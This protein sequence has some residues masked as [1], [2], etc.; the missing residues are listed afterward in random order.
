MIVHIFT[1]DRYHLV[2]IISKGFA[3]VYRHD[4][5][6]F[7]ILCGN[8]QLNK[9]L[10]D[11][12]FSEL[13]FSNYTF[14]YSYWQLIKLLIRFRSNTILFHAGNY[15]WH[16][17]ALLIGCKN[18]NWI[19]WGGGTSISNSWRSQCGA[20][21][22]KIMF[23]RY[24]SIVTLMEPERQELIRY[25]GVEPKKVRTISY[26][27]T[28]EN[29]TEFDLYCKQLAN[30]ES[31]N[32]NKPVVLLGN[33]HIWLNSYINFLPK[34]AQYR[35]KIKV[36]CMLNYPFEKG[37]AYNKLVIL[38]KSLFGDD[39]KTN[40]NFYSE[41]KDYI[42]YMN[43]CDIYMCAVE[44][45]TGLGAISYCLKLGKK[46][47][48]SGNNLE[49]VRQEYKSIVFPLEVVNE[50]LSFD[51]FVRPLSADEKKLNY[52]SQIDSNEINREKWHTYIKEIDMM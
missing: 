33:S 44:K 6:E 24:Q 41:I 21:L 51:E 18:V 1:A 20:K 43:G 42:N 30:Q 37:D 32:I 29:E 14:C 45:Q 16:L 13:S 34:L 19:C 52:Q 50:K 22:K 15:S 46:I 11:N 48:I 26:I 49:W 3:T 35:G 10:Y 7:F 39:F 28:A 40:E 17:T 31:T 2:P 12:Q 27:V 5:E 4:A 47:Y 23:N 25:F 8:S 36:Q 38:G 9:E